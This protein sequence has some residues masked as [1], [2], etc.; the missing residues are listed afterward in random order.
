MQL[1]ILAIRFTHLPP[2]TSIDIA[3]CTYTYAIFSCTIK[4]LVTSLTY[5]R[6]MTCNQPPLPPGFNY[7]TH[8]GGFFDLPAHWDMCMYGYQAPI[9]VS[10]SILFCDCIWLFYYVYIIVGL[11]NEVQKR[12]KTAYKCFCNSDHPH[13]YIQLALVRDETCDIRDKKLNEI[14]RLTLQGHVDEILKIKEPLKRGLQDIFHYNN[15]SCPRLILIVG[16]PG[17]ERKCSYCIPSV[18]YIHSCS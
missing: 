5:W 13:C 8:L 2:I 18:S 6:L 3:T 16:A 1:C 4:T 15:I 11:L 17:N 9:V 10:Y 12:L 7:H 14:T